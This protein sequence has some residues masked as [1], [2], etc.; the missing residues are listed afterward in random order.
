MA[1][2]LGKNQLTSDGEEGLLQQKTGRNT[3]NI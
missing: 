2:N 3:K 1:F